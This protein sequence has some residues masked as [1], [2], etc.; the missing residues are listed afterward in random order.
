MASSA[1]RSYEDVAAY[2]VG[3]FKDHFGLEKVEGVQK[4]TGE[5]SG[6][7]W[8]LDAKG[9]RIGGEGIVIIEVR[10]HTTAG[11]KQEDL[12]ALAYRI[13]DT[14]AVGGIIVS[15]LPIQ[16]GAKKIAGA[17]GIIE[18]TL[19]AECTN[20]EFVMAFLRQIM[21]GVTDKIAVMDDY[22][23]VVIS[24]ATTESSKPMGPRISH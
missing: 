18:V 12:A 13:M 20:T 23:A 17:E 15:P 1:W 9:V 22:V 19:N 5:R 10:R 16:E 6:T 14:G 11:Q 3:Q 8:R 21:I 2:L 7:E 4:V 24:P